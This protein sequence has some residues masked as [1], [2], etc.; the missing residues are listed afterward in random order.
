MLSI[1]ESLCTVLACSMA[2]NY[3]L[4][5]YRVAKVHKNLMLNHLQYFH[6]PEEKHGIGKDLFIKRKWI[7]QLIVINI[8]IKIA[9]IPMFFMM[10]RGYL[11][12]MDLPK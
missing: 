9:C 7:K 3:V 5:E 11:I 4:K 1:I 12:W 10:Y 2:L 6:D 8:K